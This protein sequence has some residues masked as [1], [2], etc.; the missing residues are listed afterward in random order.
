M[1][2]SYGGIISGTQ[3]TLLR[4]YAETL[5]SIV[6]KMGHTIHLIPYVE[7]TFEYEISDMAKLDL[8]EEEEKKYIGSVVRKP[9]F[10]HIEIKIRIVTLLKLEKLREPGDWRVTREREQH[11]KLLKQARI[12][13]KIV[14][15]KS[16]EY[17]PAIVLVGADPSD[18]RKE[19]KKEV[20][21]R[22]NKGRMRIKEE[23]IEVQLKGLRFPDAL[24][25]SRRTV[26]MMIMVHRLGYNETVETLLEMGRTEVQ[27]EEYPTTYDVHCA[28][29]RVISDGVE[30]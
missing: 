23:S 16:I 13:A 29:I 22:V 27:K 30:D 15:K 6:D 24:K 14:N 28:D 25:D 17:L 21:Q 8:K 19:L 7:G 10:N 20:L 11:I 9:R 26:A 3:V 12:W 2:K 1:E 4:E 5:F 18:D